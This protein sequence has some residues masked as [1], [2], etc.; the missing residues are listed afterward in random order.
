MTLEAKGNAV[1]NTYSKIFPSWS[2]SELPR[3][4]G[5]DRRNE[6]VSFLWRPFSVH[7]ARCFHW[8]LLMWVQRSL[9]HCRWTLMHKPLAEGKQEC[10][11]LMW[12]FEVHML[13][14]LWSNTG[15]SSE[16]GREET[17]MKGGREGRE[18]ICWWFLWLWA[19][20]GCPWAATAHSGTRTNSSSHHERRPS[21]HHSEERSVCISLYS[22]ISLSTQKIRRE[23]TETR[24]GLFYSKK[25]Y[26]NENFLFKFLW[27]EMRKTRLSPQISSLIG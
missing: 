14:G 23:A 25:M 12:M 18:Q 4:R 7:Q 21:S 8:L 5:L 1:I 6:R 24:A 9:W 16:A 10:V 27:K 22:L 20:S 13:S 15:K 19:V 3:N 11:S 2:T 26:E 17:G